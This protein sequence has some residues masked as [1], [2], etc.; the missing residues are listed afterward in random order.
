M[1]SCSTA[2][3]SARLSAPETRR[4]A[5]MRRARESPLW[6][7][8]DRYFQEFERVSDDRYQKR[9]GFWRPVIPR[10]IHRFLACG[11]LH[12]GFALDYTVTGAGWPSGR[13]RFRST[14]RIESPSKYDTGGR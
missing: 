9:Y 12:E 2:S 13:R 6:Q 7:L 1:R 5:S 11:D 8:L 14:V 10:T 4:Y 3:T